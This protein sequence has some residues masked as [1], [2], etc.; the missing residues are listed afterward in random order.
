MLIGKRVRLR[1]IERADLPHFVEWLND[2]DVSRGLSLNVPLSQDMEEGWFDALKNHPA[3]ERPL[4]IEIQTEEGWKLIG[5]LGLMNI[6]WLNRLAEVGI[7]IG[8]KQYWS[9]GYGRDAMVLMLRYAF[10]NL[11]FNRVWLRVFETN[12]RA[13]R[14]YEKAGFVHEGRMRQAQFQEGCFIDVLLMSALRAE[15]RDPDIIT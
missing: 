9:Q 7:F 5:N 10:N 4:G 12:R 1:A 3:E 6:S 11:G 13:V 2:P 8:E 14:S 15:W